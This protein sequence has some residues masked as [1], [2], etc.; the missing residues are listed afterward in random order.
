MHGEPEVQ[1]EFKRRLLKKG[2]RD[3]EI[4]ELHQEFGIG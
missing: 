2:F 3:V 4:P 1:T